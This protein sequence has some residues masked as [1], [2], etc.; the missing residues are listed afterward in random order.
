MWRNATASAVTDEGFETNFFV[1]LNLTTTHGRKKTLATSRTPR[2][3]AISSAY[4]VQLQ[5][6]ELV[7]RILKAYEDSEWAWEFDQRALA[8]DLWRNREVALA[9]FR[10]QLRPPEKTFLAPFEGDEDFWLQMAREN[11]VVA[12]NVYCPS[13]IRNDRN[14]LLRGCSGPTPSALCDI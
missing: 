14:F 13:K 1:F 8:P 3:K 12:L 5:H 7:L 2:K 9:R 10:C 4:E 6:P 11:G